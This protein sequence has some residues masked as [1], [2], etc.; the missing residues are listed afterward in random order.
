MVIADN[1]PPHLDCHADLAVI[2]HTSS[3]KIYGTP[4]DGVSIQHPPIYDNS[5]W[6]VAVVVVLISVSVLVSVSVSVCTVVR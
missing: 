5:G 4:L 2:G 1:E 6:L 3:G